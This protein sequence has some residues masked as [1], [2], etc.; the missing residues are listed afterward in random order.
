MYQEF[1]RELL[2]AM[3]DG[4]YFVDLDRRVTYWN[5]AAERISGYA[6]QEVLGKRCADNIL[7]HVDCDG[8]H[9]CLR[10]C[11]LAA[12][13][14]DGQLRETEV[15]MH[16][17]YGHRVPVLVRASPMRGP[18]GAITGAVE[19]FSGNA[20]GINVLQELEALRKEVL[21]DQL[22][23]IGNRRYA[24]ITLKSLDSSLAEHGVPF[25]V[26][27]VDI[28][29]FKKVNDTWGHHVGDQVL[30]MVAQTLAQ[31][32]R[33]L[34]VACRWGGEEFVLLVPNTTLESLRG[35]GDR[36]RM[37]VENCWLD[38]AD[39]QVRA[40]A[41]FGGAVSRPGENADAVVDRADRQV[42]KSKEAGRNCVHVDAAQA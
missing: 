5:K 24:D 27:F 29:H 28:D 26:L 20:K 32:L 2:D 12:T 18:D 13:M 34:D 39:K 6:A 42:Y 35:L 8:H 41:S 17:K 31:G 16:H 23:G 3:A 9:L 4:V 33:G 21:T 15:F 14:E 38:H 19:I 30:R 37:L 11:P 36:L 1:Y 40:T 10:G 22:T 25:G 7:R